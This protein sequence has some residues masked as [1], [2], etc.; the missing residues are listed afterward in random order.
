MRMVAGLERRWV[1]GRIVGGVAAFGRASGI[2]FLIIE[3]MAA[4]FLNGWLVTIPKKPQPWGAR[5]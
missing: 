1:R 3:G 5:R 4:T 2:G